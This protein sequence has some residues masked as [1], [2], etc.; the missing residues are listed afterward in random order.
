MLTYAQL[1]ESPKDF[2]AATSLTVD[3]FEHLLPVFE[4]NLAARRPAPTH[5]L[6]GQPRQRKAGAGPKEQLPTPADKLL[7]ILVYQ[8]TYPLQTMHGLQF[9]LSQP[10][11]NYWIQTLLPLLQQVLAD[12]GHRPER[13]AAAVGTSPLVNEVG[14]DLLIDGTERRRQRPTDAQRQADH[15]SGKKKAHTDKNLVLTNCH[16]QK[17]AYLSPTECGKTHDKKLADASNVVYPRGATLGKDTG[18]QGYDP[19]G[20]ITFQPKKKPK[21]QDLS[22][23]ERWLNK[24]VSSTRVR[25]ENVLAGVKRCR[26]VKEVFRNTKPGF[27]DRVMEVA[28]GLHNFRVECR[29]PLP[30]FSLRQLAT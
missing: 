29:H 22:L 2:L 4:T 24:V 6:K 30:A 19:R 27:S 12:L 14:P 13:D 21:G 11:T 23:T 8:K 26:I 25:V 7:F 20:V 5:T 15:Y 10:R 17:V 28:C 18:F 16:T 1:K 9:G 3:E